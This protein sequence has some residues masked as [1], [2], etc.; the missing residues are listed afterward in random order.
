MYLI[1]KANVFIVLLV[2]L[3]NMDVIQTK[4]GIEVRIFYNWIDCPLRKCCP[5][6]E[7]REKHLIR[8]HNLEKGRCSYNDKMFQCEAYQKFNSQTGVKKIKDLRYL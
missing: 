8:N 2:I 6:R 1:A 7:N 3:I 4:Q 5:E